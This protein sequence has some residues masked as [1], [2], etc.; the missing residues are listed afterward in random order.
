MDLTKDYTYFTFG[1][2]SHGKTEPLTHKFEFTI[3]Y[4]RHQEYL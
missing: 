2:A 4:Q 1:V 3:V